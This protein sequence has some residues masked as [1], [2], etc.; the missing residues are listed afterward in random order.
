M[1]SIKSQLILW[2]LV[3]FSATGYS[4]FL[5]STQ[6]KFG[7]YI[8][9]DFL[10]TWYNN[11]DVGGTSPLRDFHLPG[12]IPIG[13]FNRNY[14]LD[15]HVKESR[16]NFDVTTKLLGKEIHGFVELDFLL[17]S[18][19]DEKVSNSFNPRLRHF[20][21]E[22]D[23]FVIGQTWSTFMV[24]VVP[25]EIDFSGALDGLVFIRQPQI[26]YKHKNWWFALENP[27]STVNP[28][29]APEI[30]ITDSEIVPDIIVRRNFSGKWGTW[31][32][33][34]ML[35]TLHARDSTKRES[36]AGFGIT[37]GGKILLNDQNDD[38]RMMLTAGNGLGRYLAAGFIA[39]AVANEQREMKAIP[40]VNGYLAYNK[41]WIPGKLSS[42]FS[43]AYFKAFNDES[44]ASGMV[45][46]SSYSISGNLKYDPVPVLRF[47][48]EY[49]Y[50]YREVESGVN[51]SF[52]RIQLAAKYVF[53]YHN[54]EA[55]EKK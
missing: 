26:R 23:R 33:A 47:G 48:V 24:V 31:S 4:Q 39:G 19:G 35:R 38:L 51:G 37:T 20:Y 1:N 22:W 6:F 8:K 28:Y 49:A 43:V 15:Y 18:Q 25:D 34:G 50:A 21:F 45:N 13:E 12:Q 5:D 16:F 30:R 52:H 44:L 29:G 2:L 9:A 32:V 27:E 40:S 36:I 7:G 11:G 17:S 46:S 54:A 42:S 53:G 55:N 41:F 10:H 14:D 3:G